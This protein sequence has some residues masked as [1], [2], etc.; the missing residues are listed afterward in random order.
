MKG[1]DM[2]RKTTFATKASALILCFVMA[3]SAAFCI[4]VTTSHAAAKTIN[5]LMI[6]NSLTYSPK[7]KANNKSIERLKSLGSYSGYNLNVKYIAYG[8]EKLATYANSS[9]SRGKECEKLI[10]SRVWDVVVLQEETDRAIKDPSL[11]KEAAKE[12]A[13]KIKAKNPKAKILMNCTWAYDK[14][15]YGYSHAEQQKK[16]NAN[17]KNTASA[18]GASVVYSGNAFDKYR[19]SGGT[20]E[21]YLSD[22]N[23]A[24]R[25]G[26]Y[27]NACCLYLGITGKSPVGIKYHYPVGVAQ[28]TFMQKIAEQYSKSMTHD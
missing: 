6:G 11:F 9:K 10:N 25:E 21:L 1:V 23:H 8:G 16:M 28:G 2:E 14:K 19:S 12:L 7:S 5:V 26:C 18:I 15:M 27:L 24:T 4:N 17:Y 13:K 3:L 22:K 20:Y